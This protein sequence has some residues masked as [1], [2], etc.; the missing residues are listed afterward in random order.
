MQDRIEEKAKYFEKYFATNCRKFALTVEY[1]PKTNSPVVFEANIET[2]EV[3]N[4]RTRP[5]FD[6]RSKMT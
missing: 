4:C 2:D 3:I 5:I 6:T 1:P